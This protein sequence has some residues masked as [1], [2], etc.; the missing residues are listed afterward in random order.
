MV[1]HNYFVDSTKLFSSKFLEK[2]QQNLLS[3]FQF[4]T[5]RFFRVSSKAELAWKKREIV[6]RIRNLAF[7]LLIEDSRDLR[8]Y[9]K[10]MITQV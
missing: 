7:T 4:L 3:V 2:L 1:L 5:A 6:E 10:W 8:S 9:H